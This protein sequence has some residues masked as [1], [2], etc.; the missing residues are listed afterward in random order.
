MTDRSNRG[1][2]SM[3]EKKQRE[4]A[5]KGGRAAHQQGTAH[6]FTP[7]EARS[8]GRKGGEA[9]SRNREHMAHIGRLGGEASRNSPNR[10]NK[11]Q[12]IADGNGMEAALNM[13][14]SQNGSISMTPAGDAERL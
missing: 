2:A 5:S 3:D 14:E 11:K 4:I 10:R 13:T 6:E 8:A 12:E 9:I 1:F 7:E